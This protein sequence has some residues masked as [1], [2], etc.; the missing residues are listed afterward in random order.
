MKKPPAAFAGGGL[1]SAGSAK[2]GWSGSFSRAHVVAGNSN[3]G[4]GNGADVAGKKVRVGAGAKHDVV[5]SR[6]EGHWASQEIRA[7]A[8]PEM[9]G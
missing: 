3:G 4:N 2:S 9:R 7:S 8:V 1:G 5:G 6:P